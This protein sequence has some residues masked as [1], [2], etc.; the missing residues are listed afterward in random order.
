MKN[1]IFSLELLSLLRAKGI[2]A[3]L[4]FIG[5]I[6]EQDYY[7]KIVGMIES[8]NLSDAVSMLPSDTPKDRCFE[9]VDCLLLPSFVEGLSL[10]ALESQAAGIPCVASTGV[11]EDVNMGLCK[12]VSLKDKERWLDAIMEQ[13]VSNQLPDREKLK[14]LDI[15]KW[16]EEIAR[17]YNAK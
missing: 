15:Q 14:N 8:L 5:Y 3:K 4:T 12:Y 10:V 1:Q 7:D 17:L 9:T 6:L 11:P 16:I 13:A 2:D